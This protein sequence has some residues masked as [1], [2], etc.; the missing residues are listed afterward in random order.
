MRQIKSIQNHLLTAVLSGML[1]FYICAICYLNLS[2]TPKFY[3]SDMYADILVSVQMWQE[4]SLFPENW[5]FGNQ[6]YVF[7]TP[8]LSAFLY[9]I[10]GSPFRSMGAAACIMAAAALAGFAWMLRP[11]FPQLKDRLLAL[12]VFLG[13]GVFFGDAVRTINGWQL[14]FTMCAYYACYVLTLFLAFGCY[15][16]SETQIPRAMLALSCL[17]SFAMGIQSLRQTVVMALPLAAFEGVRFL[18]RLRK[19]Q[20]LFTG[21]FWT[22]VCIFVSN[23]G[24]LLCKRFLPVHQ[25][26]FFDNPAFSSPLNYPGNAAEGVFNMLCLF[27]KDGRKPDFFC[28]LWLGMFVLLTLIVCLKNRKSLF[29][30]KGTLPLLLLFSVLAVFGIDVMTT[31]SIRPIYYFTLYPLIAVLAAYLFSR[32]NRA[33]Q[34]VVFALTCTMFLLSCNREIFPSYKQAQEKKLDLHYEISEKLLEDGI[35]VVYSHWNGCERI[36]VASNGK[37]RAAFWGSHMFRPAR[38]LYN[39][40]VYQ[41]TPQS[42]AYVFYGQ[43]ELEEGMRKAESL[44]I[45]LILVAEYPQKEIYIYTAPVNFLQLYSETG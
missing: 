18:I 10:T 42:A 11:V 16:R 4:K 30:L 36:A 24:G 41:A 3:I 19:Q 34:V 37:I 45:P 38:Y 33:V 5:V 9:G 20:S 26:E 22:M 17:L 27:F 2:V 32:Q 25:V 15:V 8:V 23:L 40:S 7:S 21:S 1:L 44:N 43:K 12:V 39:P 13:L 29:S 35:E 31:M 28:L 14:L 6:L